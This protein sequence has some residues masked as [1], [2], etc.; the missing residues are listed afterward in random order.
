MLLAMVGADGADWDSLSV[1]K[2][3]SMLTGEAYLVSVSLYLWA[4][5]YSVPA[6]K[7]EKVVESCHA[8]SPLLYSPPVRVSNVIDVSV[9]LAMVGAEGVGWASLFLLPPPF[10]I[11]IF[12][13]FL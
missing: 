8:S 11:T 1:E 6:D 2:D 5:E 4:K 3:A 13:S 9:L 10:P 7:S 12:V